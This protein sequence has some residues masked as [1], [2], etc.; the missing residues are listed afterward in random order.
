MALQNK[1]NNEKLLIRAVI[2]GLLDVL[3][4]Q[5]EYEQVWSNDDI[6]T[7][8]IPWFYNQS[9]DER[10][11]QDFYT[12]YS[13]CAPVP[14]DGNFDVT[15]R[16]IITYTGSAVNT[17]RMTSRYVQG[18][19]LKQVDGQLQSYSSYL[20]PIPFDVKIACEIQPNGMVPALKIEQV[21]YETF[22]RTLTYY[23]YFKGMRIGCTV[24]FPETISTENIVAYS[25]D[26]PKQIKQTFELGIETYLPVFDQTTEVNSNSRIKGFGIRLYSPPE[27]DDGRITVVSPINNSTLY[28]NANILIEWNYDREGAIINRVDLYWQY[29]SSTNTQW[30]TIE[31]FIPNHEYY[32]WNVPQS[33]TEYKEPTIIFDETQSLNLIRPPLIKIIPD[34]VTKLIDVSSFIILDTGYFNTGNIDTSIGIVLEMKNT[35]NKITYTNEGAIKINLIGNKIDLTNPVYIEP[36]IYFTGNI[37][38]KDINII[39]ANSVNPEHYGIINNVKIV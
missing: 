37:D 9:G 19:Y 18:Q 4:N 13:G 11:M 27:K 6:E 10:F 24:G 29:N 32:L 7:I 39:V 20:R 36:S 30:Y 35:H 25:Y 8:K 15:P 1:Y 14:I 31:K 38:Y 26:N 28:K 21:I 34:L 17:Q 2:A 3:N 5:L 16:G 12:H 22:F 33:F 23:V